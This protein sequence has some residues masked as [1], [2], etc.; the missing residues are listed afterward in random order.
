M[1]EFY[2]IS[3]VSWMTYLSFD[4][5]FKIVRRSEINLISESL[6]ACF[7]LPEYGSTIHIYIYLPVII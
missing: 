5:F 4:Q 6:S 7:F 1:G 2:T 3:I